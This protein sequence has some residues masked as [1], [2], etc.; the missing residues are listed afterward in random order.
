MFVHTTGAKI[1]YN[2]GGYLFFVRFAKRD[3]FFQFF[4][5]INQILFSS[6]SILQKKKTPPPFEVTW[7]L[8]DPLI[9]LLTHSY[10]AHSVA[11]LVY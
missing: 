10:I 5:V 8:N 2:R 1:N 6:N 3:I 4:A 7:S 9:I 11:C